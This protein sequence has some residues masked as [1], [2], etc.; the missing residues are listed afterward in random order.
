MAIDHVVKQGEGIESI[1]FANGWFPDALW[2]HPSNEELA[3]KRATG[4]V[5]LPGD[6]VHVPDLRPK[7]IEVPTGGRHRFQRKGV[8]SQFKMKLLV[9]NAS[10]AGIPYKLVIDDGRLTL[11]GTTGGGGEVEAWI[12]PDAKKAVITTELHTIETSLA[13]LDPVDSPTGLVDRLRNLEYL[14]DVAEGEIDPDDL[15]DAVAAFQDEHGLPPTG[16]ADPDTRQALMTAHG[17]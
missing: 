5:L 6:V 14:D 15:A 1:A 7:S 11:Q 3:K 16:K 12:P 4:H 13:Y 2:N 17:S 9:D 8:P 10:V